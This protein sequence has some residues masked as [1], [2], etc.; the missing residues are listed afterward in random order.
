MV[1]NLE[2]RILYIKAF[3]YSIQFLICFPK[4]I[5]IE[6]ERSARMLL[7]PSS[8]VMIGFQ[9]KKWIINPKLRVYD[10]I[11]STVKQRLFSL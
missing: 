9:S 7:F 1:M 10:S 11:L 5:L 6:V 3:I 4:G 8:T 2:G